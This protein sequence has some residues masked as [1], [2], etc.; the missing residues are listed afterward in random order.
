MSDGVTNSAKVSIDPSS[1]STAGFPDF[2]HVMR[3]SPKVDLMI[4]ITVD[5]IVAL[6]VVLVNVE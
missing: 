6:D 1:V 2:I 5:T 3:T 4:S